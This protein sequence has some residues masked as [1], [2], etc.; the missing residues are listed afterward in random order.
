MNASFRGV[1]DLYWLSAPP[2]QAA[3]N[4]APG[5]PAQAAILALNTAT[6]G[7]RLTGCRWYG[8][9]RGCNYQDPTGVRQPIRIMWRQ[10]GSARYRLPRGAQ[11]AA[12]W[13][14][15]SSAAAGSR[16]KVGTTP[17]ILTWL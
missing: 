4:L 16:I 1:R 3:V 14:A 12:V 2:G 9:L 13:G 15:T 8:S 7:M 11:I 17:L 5:T 10:Y 6:Q